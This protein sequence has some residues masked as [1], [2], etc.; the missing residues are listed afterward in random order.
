MSALERD[1]T[2]GSR[3]SLSRRPFVV[4]ALVV[5]LLLQGFAA[6]GASLSHAA[7]E[8][9]SGTYLSALLAATCGHHAPDDEGAP[10]PLAR[11][12][13]CCVLCGAADGGEAPLPRAALTGEAIFPDAGERLTFD[14]RMR[15]G[16][17]RRPP[18]F[19]SAWSSQAPPFFS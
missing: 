11:H 15:V 6:I 10:V 9:A 8:G 4:A 1:R 7:R 12:A 18:G 2:K 17:D 5:L 3:R 19:A 16:F 13:P 14:P